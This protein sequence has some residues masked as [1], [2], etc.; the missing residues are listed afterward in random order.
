MQVLPRER[1]NLLF[2]ATL[3]PPLAALRA[4]FL[5]D[6]F[7]FDQNYADA[8]EHAAQTAAHAGGGAPVDTT[9]LG[10]AAGQSEA[11]PGDESKKQHQV[12]RSVTGLAAPP[13]TLRQ[14]YSLVPAQ[15]CARC[16]CLRCIRWDGAM[17]RHAVVYGNQPSLHA[18][19]LAAGRPAPC[20]LCTVHRK[21]YCSSIS[22]KVFVDIPEPRRSRRLL[23]QSPAVCA[24]V[25]EAYLM[26]AL[27][28]VGSADATCSHLGGARSAIVFCG[29]QR[30]ADAVAALLVQ[31]DVPSAALHGGK[32]QKARLAA[33][34]QVRTS[35]KP[36]FLHAR[37]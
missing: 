36:P 18:P 30:S 22:H 15:V 7:L 17:V 20:P 2:S 21:S 37:V 25:K 23:R 5:R 14:R 8:I 24:Q 28:Q 29:T 1:Q 33:L 35:R 16:N 31:L 34:H 26:H 10:T 9:E 12:G 32:A 13:P 11:N 19:L 6:P 4:S 3:T 27:W